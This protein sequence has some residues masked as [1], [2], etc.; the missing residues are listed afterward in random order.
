MF[1]KRS[2]LFPPSQLLISLNLW[3]D[4]AAFV[5]K[6][7]ISPYLLTLEIARHWTLRYATSSVHRCVN[8][9][10]TGWF[11]LDSFHL[12]ESNWKQFSI[13][14]LRFIIWHQAESC[15]FPFETS[16]SEWDRCFLA[17]DWKSLFTAPFPSKSASTG[18][19]QGR[20]S[21]NVCG[22]IS[23]ALEQKEHLRSLK[24]ERPSQCG[25][26]RESGKECEG[27]CRRS[28]SQ[29]RMKRLGHKLLRQPR[30]NQSLAIAD[31]AKGLAEGTGTWLGTESLN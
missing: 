22:R 8:M 24:K 18:R 4:S 6:Y 21:L 12:L 2:V 29:A 19:S 13:R 28:V 30:G 14:V 27:K 15:D 23:H 25:G 5:I 3:T 26:R 11:G 1:W 16:Y 17:S 20:L 9:G 31:G 7:D 10:N